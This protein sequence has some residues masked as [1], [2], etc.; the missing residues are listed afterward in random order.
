MTAVIDERPIQYN[1][2]DYP[3][4]VHVLAMYKWGYRVTAHWHAALEFV[5]PISGAATI[6]LNGKPYALQH[7][8]GILI[9]VNRIHALSAQSGSDTRLLVVQLQP[10]LLL[11]GAAPGLALH[12]SDAADD[13]LLLD[14]QS[15]WQDT[16]LKQLSRLGN[17]YRFGGA[18]ALTAYMESLAVTARCVPHLQLHGAGHGDE[19][20]QFMQMRSYIEENYQNEVPIA[21]IA[22]S[23]GVG[24]SRCFEIFAIC[25]DQ[26]PTE[27]VQFCRLR[28]AKQLLMALNLDISEVARRCGF[29]SASY[30][31]KQFKRQ[32]GVT[33]RD[34]RHTVR[35]ISN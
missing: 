19:Q 16:V 23:G 31:S 5:L 3:L 20:I 21:A 18:D 4:A 22:H 17:Y 25:A 32:N 7:N 9:N 29:K 28:H 24:R 11:S 10:D 1:F 6:T 33:P 26:T 15:A 12:L 27:Y 2:G 13:F 14:S 30:F 34:Y 35:T 8:L